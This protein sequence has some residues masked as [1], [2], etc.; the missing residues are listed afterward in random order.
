M[1]D[2]KHAVS[3]LILASERRWYIGGMSTQLCQWKMLYINTLR[4]RQDSSHFP[5][6]IFKYIFLNENVWIFVTISLKFV[7]KGSINNIPSLVQIMAWPWSGDKPLSG[8]ILAFFIDAYM[9]H[10]AS[11]SWV[12]PFI[13][14]SEQND[15]IFNVIFHQCIWVSVCCD[16]AFMWM[17][18]SHDHKST[19]TAPSHSLSQCW[20]RY[21]SPYGITRPQWV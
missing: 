19:L 10:S 14:I 5:T 4:P 1:E 3:S 13:C 18:I 16:I 2:V 7:P 20:P 6:D 21:M 9:R 11:M 17:T 8:P 15:Y 12:Y